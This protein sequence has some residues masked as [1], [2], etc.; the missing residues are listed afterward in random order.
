MRLSAKLLEWA[1]WKINISAPD[2]DKCIICVA[3]HTSNWDFIL[4]LLAY[5]SVGRHAGFLMK[6][7]WFFFPLGYFFK[8]IGGIPVP[9]RKK[10]RSVVDVV[11]EKFNTAKKLQ[12]AITPEGTRSRTTKW[13]TGFIQ[14][15][16]QAKVPCLLGIIDFETKTITIDKIFNPSGDID[17]DMAYIKSFYTPFKGKYPH[18]FT[19]SS[20]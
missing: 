7:S 9:R 15:S 13:H 17:A 18:K 10:G 11:V 6:D 14:I 16:L 1:G 4:G 19:T 20:E 5:D 8:A 2:L 3:P 12:I